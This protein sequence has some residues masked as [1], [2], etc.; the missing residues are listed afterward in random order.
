MQLQY[1]LAWVVFYCVSVWKKKEKATTALS[2]QS[3]DDEPG[4]YIVHVKLHLAAVRCILSLI[5]PNFPAAPDSS[6]DYIYIQAATL[7]W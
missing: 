2:C 7:C 3:L 5:G 1:Q 6:H 4:I